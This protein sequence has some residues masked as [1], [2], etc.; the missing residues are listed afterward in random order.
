MKPYY[1]FLTPLLL[2]AC[3]AEMS[4][5]VEDITESHGVTCTVAPIVNGNEETKA[6]VDFSGSTIN[7]MWEDGDVIGVVPLDDH[8]NQTNYTVHDTD[9][10]SAT[11]DGGSWAVK[12]GQYLAYYP[13]NNTAANSTSTLSGFS[14]VGQ[15]QT[16]NG[17]TSH[18]GGLNFMSATS[19]CTTPGSVNFAFTTW[20]AKLRIRFDVPAGKY[21]RMELSTDE[22]LFAQS[23][24]L[25]LSDG[26][27]TAGDFATSIA[28]ELEDVE[29]ASAGTLDMWITLAPCDQ[30]NKNI[31]I[32]VTDE[33]GNTIVKDLKG[34]NMKSGNYYDYPNRLSEHVEFCQLPKGTEFNAAVLAAAGE[35]AENIH[36]VT[37]KTGQVVTNTTAGYDITYNSATN[38]V[39]VSTNAEEFKLNANSE[40]MFYN[41][42]YTTEIAGLEKLNTA[43]V[44]NFSHFFD[45]CN[46]LSNLDLSS[47]DTSSA[48]GMLNTFCNCSALTSLDIS[49]FDVS[50][51]TNMNNLFTGCSNL[52]SLNLGAFNAESVQYINAMF[53]NCPK[54]ESIDLSGMN[55]TR[56]NTMKSVFYNCSS[57][58]SLDLSGLDT[59]NV[60]D[61]NKCFNG[62]TN[63]A[64]LNLTGWDLDKVMNST[65]IFKDLGINNYYEAGETY[66]GRESSPATIFRCSEETWVKCLEWLNE[67]GCTLGMYKYGNEIP[68]EPALLPSGPDFNLKIA[69]LVN[70]NITSSGDVD[71]IEAALGQIEYLSFEECTPTNIL[72]VKINDGYPG[73]YATYS[74]GSVVVKTMAP[75]GFANNRQTFMADA[76]CSKMFNMF[77]NLTTI[78]GFECVNTSEVTTMSGMFNCCRNLTYVD[79]RHINTENVNYMS[80]MFSGCS[81]LTSENCNLQSFSTGNVTSMRNMFEQCDAMTEI[82]LSSFDTGKCSNFVGMFRNCEH[83]S[84]IVLGDYFTISN[85]ANLNSF[86]QFLGTRSSD[87]TVFYCRQ[88][89]WDKLTG[90]SYTNYDSSVHKRA[91][92][93]TQLPSASDILAF[94]E[95]LKPYSYWSGVKSITFEVRSSYTPADGQSKKRLTGTTG[96]PVYVTR[97]NSGTVYFY[98]SADEYTLAADAS[99]LFMA[100]S[101]YGLEHL[102]TSQVT[103]MSEMFAN[104]RNTELDLKSWDVSNVTNMERIFFESSG[105]E[106]LESLDISSWNTSKVTNF[107]SMFYGAK[108]LHTV[109]AGKGFVIGNNASYSDIASGIGTFVSAADH[110]GYHTTFYGLLTDTYFKLG[111]DETNYNYVNL[112]DDNLGF[113]GGDTGGNGRPIV[114]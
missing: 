19:E 54:L 35:D 8:T 98:T 83:T 95:T 20:V 11:C 103:N 44:T 4:D 18:L 13:Y 53:A 5:P 97:D 72:G 26:T 73:I 92:T 17:S 80:D 96:A 63:L 102:N 106:H 27:W 91:E 67:S 90:T 62:C 113:D 105:Y 84:K 60:T 74:E 46:M 36:K 41:F 23:A 33:N 68:F 7:F 75:N 14:L 22:P 110:N 89:T 71:L 58:K 65:N 31:R 59:S 40:Q 101:V 1:V 15:R 79:L 42:Y 49:N 94:L 108:R 104:T 85:N 93:T 88:D 100:V 2:A 61:I 109:K 76:D 50:K 6:T 64:H 66:T 28:L 9:G 45:N 77:I 24:S 56:V 43:E 81:A 47:F 112:P 25:S 12:E 30:R 87:G 57:L 3:T 52:E 34:M 114:D 16:E 38:E 32:T 29:L 111:L 107:N 78:S 86:F 10:S 48:T 37:F 70:P 82:D 69:Q 51:V 55:T 21:T 99:G 39:V